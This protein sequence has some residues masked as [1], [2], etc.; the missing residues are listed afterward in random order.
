MTPKSGANEVAEVKE[1]IVFSPILKYL[2]HVYHCSFQ[3]L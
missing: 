1:C 3:A 2:H